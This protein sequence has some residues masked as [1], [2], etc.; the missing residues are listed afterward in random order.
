[1]ARFPPHP[2][3]RPAIVTGASSGI[4]AA[5]A[6][7]LGAAGFPVVLGARRVERCEEVADAVRRGGGEATAL[8]VDVSD[9]T[10]VEP[11]VAE[12]TQRVGDIEVL[13]SCAGEIA[14]GAAL[15]T[16]D[17]EFA[18]TLQVNV[19]GSHRLVAL[20]ASAMVDRGRGDLVFVTSDTARRPRPHMAAYSASKWA[21]EGYA[22][23]LQMELEGTGVRASIVQPGPTR[24][25]MGTDWSEA[26]TAKVIDEWTRWGMARHDHFMRPEEVATAV[27]TAVSARRGTHF[28]LI[29]V[30]PEAPLEKGDT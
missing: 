11:F 28:T 24:T 25:E 10:T 3:R 30:N 26:V 20:V 12:A 13:V 4:G 23:S 17:A 8:F 19:L 15:Q 6:R 21:L 27:L 22:R 5:C 1:M 7:A 9:A 2:Q 16:T 14:P 29:E 18:S